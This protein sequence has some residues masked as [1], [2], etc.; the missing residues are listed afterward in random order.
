MKRALIV[1]S[2]LAGVIGVVVAVLAPE[3]RSL[4]VD[5]TRSAAA[6]L[7]DSLEKSEAVGELSGDWQVLSN[8]AYDSLL[9]VLTNAGASLDACPR[10][11]TPDGKFGDAWGERFQIL[12]RRRDG[13]REYIIWSKG[14]DRVSGSDDD[15]VFPESQRQEVKTILQSE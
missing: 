11:H 13:R 10:C 8:A 4:N 2:T 9:L 14:P 15:I 1:I 6:S 5:T 7:H 12:A 3:L